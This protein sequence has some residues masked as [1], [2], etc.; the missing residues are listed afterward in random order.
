[1]IYE[2]TQGNTTLLFS[3]RQIIAYTKAFVNDI[4]V[5]FKIIKSDLG[6]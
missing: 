5:V 2:H 4:A 6:N 1:M 3:P